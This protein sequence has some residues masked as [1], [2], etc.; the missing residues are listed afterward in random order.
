MKPLIVYI[1]EGKFWVSES[2]E[3][4]ASGPFDPTAEGRS[5]LAAFFRGK[6]APDAVGTSSTVDFPE[7]GGLPENF[8]A[9]GFITGALD[10][11]AR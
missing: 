2:D 8:D 5:A 9:H 11:A 4:P 1:S 3:L 7:D 10:E 6:G